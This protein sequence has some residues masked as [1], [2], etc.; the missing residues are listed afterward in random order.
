MN[1]FTSALLA[2]CLLVGVA[3]GPTFASSPAGPT[4]GD[5]GPVY[6][7]STEIRY[8][9]SDPV[10]VQ[11]LVSGSLP[12][13]CHDPVFEVQDLGDRIDVLLWSLADPDAMCIQVLEPFE[14]AIPLGSFE[15]A[16]LPV[17]LNGQEVGRIIIGAEGSP[18][19]L[20]GAGWSFGFCLE[21]CVAD[22][23]IDG[24]DLVLTGRPRQ[25]A[26]PSYVNRGTLT[27]EGLARLDAAVAAL[28]G[29]ALEPRYGCP[30]CADGGAF[31]LELRRGDVVER[32]TTEY[33]APPE[34]LAEVTAIASELI[35]ALESCTSGEL[36]E[37]AADCVAQERG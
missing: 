1:G 28:S 24:D 9:E 5:P 3:G 31:S 17:F 29:V 13:P 20:V 15:S 36:V 32:V 6:V 27:A 26:E 7:D 12:T 2:A 21:Y 35:S 23:V 19:A 16:D 34:I 18:D 4:G 30:D 22:L 8:L 10:Q 25:D 33:G 37:V 14:L 11:L